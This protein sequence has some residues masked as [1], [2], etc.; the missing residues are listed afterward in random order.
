MPRLHWRLAENDGRKDL[1]LHEL[2]D[3]LQTPAFRATLRAGA[4]SVLQQKS[5]VISKLVHGREF[6]I[7]RG[8]P[9]Y[10]LHPKLAEPKI[11]ATAAAGN[12]PFA[13]FPWVAPKKDRRVAASPARS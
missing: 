9:G 11:R 13:A 4:A 7:C 5:E 12:G 6:I 3:P 2:V 10:Q 8:D 1:G